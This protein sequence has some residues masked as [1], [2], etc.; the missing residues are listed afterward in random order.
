[1]SSRHSFLMV[2]FLATL[3]CS[4]YP[5]H[6]PDSASPAAVAAPSSC[7]QFDAARRPEV[8]AATVLVSTEQ[9]TGSGFIIDN[10]SEQLVISNYHVVA[11]G[12]RHVADITLPDGSQRRT[13]LEVVKVSRERD[14]AL[15]KPLGPV[16]SFRLALRA[17]T[18]AI[19]TSVTVLGYPGVAGSNPVLT[20]EPGTVTASSRQLGGVDY[21]QTNANINPGNSGGPLV[22]GCGQVL[23]VVSGRHV[24]TER[25]G[26]A[27]P[28]RAVN[29]LL[30]EYRKPPLSP[31]KTAESQ[32]QR[33]FT[34]VKFRRSDKVS[35]FFAREYVEKRAREDLA[36]VAAS[37]RSK[38]EGV[39]ALLRKS[40]RDLS[41]MPEAEST[42]LLLTKLTPSEL[43]ANALSLRV[44]EKKLSEY[45][46][47]AAWLTF[48]SAD[49][50]GSLDDVWVENVS[51][52]KSGC[53]DAYATVADGGQTR[54]YIVHLHHQHGEWLVNEV[55]QAR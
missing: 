29:D 19:G 50:F 22:D 10:D 15:L 13:P 11:S 24:S 55:K 41:K 31:E 6:R 54:R 52:T 39:V 47:A 49:M 18:P 37:A 4:G 2:P 28:A 1:M 33:F 32:L 40:G 46:A 38:I 48:G 30:A 53:M 34:E 21:I 45:D 51:L 17:E 14:L 9:S 25:L 16:G 26:L 44:S 23:G 3:A 27:I 42:K 7:T 43:Y 8:S 5:G 35:Q 12:T 20:L 36:R